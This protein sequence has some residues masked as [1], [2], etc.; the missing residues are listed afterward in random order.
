MPTESRK[1]SPGGRSWTRQDAAVRVMR[2]RILW[3]ALA[4]WLV[5]AF[6]LWLWSSPVTRENANR[7]LKGMTP[8]EVEAILGPPAYSSPRVTDAA[9]NAPGSHGS[10]LGHTLL[11]EWRGHGLCIRVY[12]EPKGD[13]LRV[14]AVESLTVEEKSLAA[15]LTDWFEGQWDQYIRRR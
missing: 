3:G 14:T 7:I 11:R 2:R 1:S 13:I 5:G 6:A 4:F 9:L 12:F 15:I 8:G 10:N